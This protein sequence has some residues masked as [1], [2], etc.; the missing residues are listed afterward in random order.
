[1]QHATN[2]RSITSGK[3]KM[4]GIRPSGV[5]SSSGKLGPF[6]RPLSAEERKQQAE[7]QAQIIQ[8]QLFAKIKSQSDENQT[9]KPRFYER[10]AFN[11]PEYWRDTCRGWITEEEQRNDHADFETRR[12]R[13]LDSK[14]NKAPP[15][16]RHGRGAPRSTKQFAK[17]MSTEAAR[18]DRLTPQSK[19]LLQVLVARTGKGRSTDTTKTTLG[20]IM[21]RCP[22]SIQRYVRELIKFGYIRTQTI[23]SRRTGFFVGMRIWIMNSVLPFF[24]NKKDVYNP[25][26]WLDL[27]R[28][29]RDREGT[30]ESL[31][32]YKNKILNS[33]KEKKPP[34]FGEYAF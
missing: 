6:L 24:A 14:H 20:I 26:E 34:W 2:Q 33:Y 11:T 23:K 21:N 22:R 27:V 4:S 31:T 32:N 29:R 10:P 9:N 5:G 17:P 16:E 7:S 30:K 18:D 1:M 3:L 13:A 19:A 12:R 25:E 8:R 15:P 28:N